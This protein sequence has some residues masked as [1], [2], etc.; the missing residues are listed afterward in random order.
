[1]FSWLFSNVQKISIEE[2]FAYAEKQ[3]KYLYT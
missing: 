3:K 1:M 2:R